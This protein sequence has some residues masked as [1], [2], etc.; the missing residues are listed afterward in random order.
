MRASSSSRYAQPQRLRGNAQPVRR[1]PSQRG[2]DGVGIIAL[3]EIGDR[4]FVQTGKARFERAQ[5]LLQDSRQRC[6]RSP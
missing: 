6:G 1:G 2:A 4:D 5:G 3:A